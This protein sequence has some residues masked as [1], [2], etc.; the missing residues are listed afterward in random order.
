VNRSTSANSNDPKI[1]RLLIKACQK[2]IGKYVKAGDL[3][4]A[5][6]LGKNTLLVAGNDSEWHQRIIDNLNDNAKPL[7]SAV[8]QSHEPP[9]TKT[10]AEIREFTENILNFPSSPKTSIHGSMDLLVGLGAILYKMHDLTTAENALRAAI[11][12]GNEASGETAAITVR[13]LT[14]LGEL[15]PFGRAA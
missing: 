11:D 9:K 8:W 12:I 10:S 1:K 15:C 5:S 7:I 4:K 2:R 6:L 3:K 14:M 13:A